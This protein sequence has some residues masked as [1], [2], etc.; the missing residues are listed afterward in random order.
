[1]ENQSQFISECREIKLNINNKS[2]KE[3]E[4]FELFQMA[5]LSEDEI[6][7]TKQT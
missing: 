4:I 2:P 6:S 5:S 1:M 3:F 7:N